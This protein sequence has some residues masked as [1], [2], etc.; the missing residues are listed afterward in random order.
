MRVD[1]SAYSCAHTHTH[2]SSRQWDAELRRSAR[3][4]SPCFLLNLD[5]FV[6]TVGYIRVTVDDG[7]APSC[8][9]PVLD[10]NLI[11]VN[12]QT[13][14]CCHCSHACAL[15]FGRFGFKSLWNWIFG[16]DNTA[17]LGYYSRAATK[18]FIL[19]IYLVKT[20]LASWHL[21]RAGCCMRNYVA[22][23]RA[24]VEHVI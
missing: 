20:W 21:A 11:V 8:G 14:R 15:G 12:H 6:I 4:R 2:G 22:I 1:E 9:T 17:L 7:G 24:W 13:H 5:I 19:M 10:A 23:V 16:Y 18:V 3:S